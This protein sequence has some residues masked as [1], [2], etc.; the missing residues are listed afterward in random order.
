MGF[1]WAGR[2]QAAA[3]GHEFRHR[4]GSAPSLGPWRVTSLPEAFGTSNAASVGQDP[5]MRVEVEGWGQPGF[6]LVSGWLRNSWGYV[7]RCVGV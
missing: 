3:V 6:S 2:G 5:W 7:D 4:A 1:P